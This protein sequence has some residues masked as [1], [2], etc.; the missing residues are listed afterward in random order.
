MFLKNIITVK[1]D[2]ISNLAFASPSNEIN[3]Y[4]SILG[5]CSYLIAPMYVALS[6]CLNTKHSILY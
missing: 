3:V 5:E 1:R 4:R 6:L 2:Q